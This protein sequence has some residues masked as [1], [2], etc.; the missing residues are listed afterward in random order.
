MRKADGLRA[1]YRD[2]VGPDAELHQGTRSQELDQEPMM[3]LGT[4]GAWHEA[5][6]GDY[7]PLVRARLALE[8]LKQVASS[9]L[10]ISNVRLS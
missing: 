2:L 6:Y 7:P 5:E 9:D 4:I 1:A 10:A 3:R 8:L